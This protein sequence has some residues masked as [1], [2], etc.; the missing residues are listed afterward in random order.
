MSREA[1]V[2]DVWYNDANTNALL[3]DNKLLNI[4]R[5]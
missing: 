3:Q 4:T 2:A 1:V 5:G